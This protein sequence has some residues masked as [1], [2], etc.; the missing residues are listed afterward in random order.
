[1]ATPLSSQ[2]TLSSSD[3]SL[4]HICIFSGPAVSI[5]FF[6]DLFEFRSGDLLTYGGVFAHRFHVPRH[7]NSV[8]FVSRTALLFFTSFVLLSAWLSFSSVIN[9]SG[10]DC[11]A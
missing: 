8:V 10:D 7:S 9:A 5:R 3:Y 4:E 6:V 11:H 2:C 1:M